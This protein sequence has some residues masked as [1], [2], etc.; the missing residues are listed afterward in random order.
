MCESVILLMVARVLFVLPVAR[1]LSYDYVQGIHVV[2]R[3]PL[4]FPCVVASVV[5]RILLALLV[6]FCNL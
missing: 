4:S 5:V 1:F 3:N 2:Y 6:E